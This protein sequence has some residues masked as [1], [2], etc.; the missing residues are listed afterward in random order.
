MVAASSRSVHELPKLVID[1]NTPTSFVDYPKEISALS[2]AHGLLRD[3]AVSEVDDMTV[4]NLN[5]DALA[6]LF[7]DENSETP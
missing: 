6:A 5:S 1:A 4:V 3:G 2:F 7:G